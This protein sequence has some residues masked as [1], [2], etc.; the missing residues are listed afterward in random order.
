MA[1]ARYREPSTTICYRS[2]MVMVEFSLALHPITID[3]FEPNNLSIQYREET[4]VVVS[5][6]VGSTTVTGLS[7]ILLQFPI[8]PSFPGQVCER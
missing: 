6:S 2:V 3:T 1:Y 5:Y 8:P 7:T 4:A